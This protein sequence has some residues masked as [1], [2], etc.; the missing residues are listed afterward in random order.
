MEKKRGGRAAK[1]DALR[2]SFQRW[3]E[4]YEEQTENPSVDV[5][6]AGTDTDRDYCGFPDFVYRIHIVN[7]YESLSLG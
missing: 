6:F 3:G 1:K 7:Q 4:Q 2:P 5:Q